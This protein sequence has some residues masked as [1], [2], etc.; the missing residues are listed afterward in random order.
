MWRKRPNLCIKLNSRNTEIAYVLFLCSKKAWNQVT[1]KEN[2]IHK[3]VHV[4]KQ[5]NIF[6]EANSFVT[7]VYDDEN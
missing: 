5:G 2:R 1:L 6:Q 4:A 7:T 3:K